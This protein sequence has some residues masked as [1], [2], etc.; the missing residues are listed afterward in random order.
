MRIQSVVNQAKSILGSATA[1]QVLELLRWLAGR[2]SNQDPSKYNDFLAGIGV[3]GGSNVS[4]PS[5]TQSSKADLFLLNDRKNIWKKKCEEDEDVVYYLSVIA[6][7]KEI[8]G[9][10]TSVDDLL[11]DEDFVDAN[12]TKVDSDKYLRGRRRRENLLS[13]VGLARDQN[14]QLVL[15]LLDTESTSDSKIP[16]DKPEE[17]LDKI[18]AVLSTK[19]SS[20]PADTTMQIEWLQRQQLAMMQ[21]MSAMRPPSSMYPAYPPQGG[22]PPRGGPP[23]G[24]AGFHYQTMGQPIGT[25]QGGF[26]ND[27]YSNWLL[28]T[29][30]LQT[31]HWGDSD[32]ASN[33][34]VEDRGTDSVGASGNTNSSTSAPIQVKG[35]PVRV[36]PSPAPDA[37]TSHSDVTTQPGNR[38][39]V[40]ASSKDQRLP[41]K[42]PPVPLKTGSR[43]SSK[44]PPPAPS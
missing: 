19:E 3:S 35:K 23:Q 32:E 9:V 28:G 43:T 17:T 7:T 38:E 10:N 44:S 40:E 25:P 12:S 8:H 18:L 16:D 34:A 29:A 5:S 27:G 42:A 24:D 20:A 22:F 31:R 39:G 4:P 11:G 13:E 26:D 6:H 37:S 2:L 14:G 15:G 33:A 21:M 1:G 36:Q 41:A 30:A